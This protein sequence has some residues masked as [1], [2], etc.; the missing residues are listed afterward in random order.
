MS[1]EIV[2][3]LLGI[4][5]ALVLITVLI[6][7]G[8]NIFVVAFVSSAVVALTG[9]LPMYEALKEHFV[10]GFVGFFKANYLIFLTGTLMGKMM[11]VTNGAKAIAKLIVKYLGKDKALISIPLACAILAYGG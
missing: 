4:I 11:E 2:V 1:G 3:S 8:V 9:G 10:S 7:K 6:M 5:V